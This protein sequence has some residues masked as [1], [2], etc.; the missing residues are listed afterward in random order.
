MRRANG[1]QDD[2][3]T[4]A[5]D[6]RAERTTETTMGLV[7]R[8]GVVVAAALVAAG[9]LAYLVERRGATAHYQTFGAA[10]TFTAPGAVLRGALALDP[11]AIVALGLLVLILT[12]VARVVFALGA[13]ALRRDRLYVAFSAI[14]LAVLAIGLTGHVL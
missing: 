2:R 6:R 10:R 3:R 12:P 4:R 5:A 8:I 1:R 9:G 11:A 13:F 14:V 7:L